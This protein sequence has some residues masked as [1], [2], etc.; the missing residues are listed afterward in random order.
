MVEKGWALGMPEA[1][2][3]ASGGGNGRCENGI[4]AGPA[5]ADIWRT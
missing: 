2:K 5:L 4:R 1:G 3:V